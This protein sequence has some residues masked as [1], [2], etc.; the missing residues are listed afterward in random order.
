[1][2]LTF[3]F[4]SVY[5]PYHKYCVIIVNKKLHLLLI[6][7]LKEGRIMMMNNC[8]VT[9]NLQFHIFR[10][11]W[12]VQQLL[13]MTSV[14]VFGESPH[15]RYANGSPA[16]DYPRNAVCG[17]GWE[18]ISPTRSVLKPRIVVAPSRFRVHRQR[19]QPDYG[20]HWTTSLESLV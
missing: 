3:I 2:L 19:L 11:W 15:R 18:I 14:G 13:L 7:H 8:R 12:V 16:L 20:V 4:T 10:P 17:V 5:S 9:A 6:V 1:M